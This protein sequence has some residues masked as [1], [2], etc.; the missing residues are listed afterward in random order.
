MDLVGA[1]VSH[2]HELLHLSNRYFCGFGAIGVEVLR[3]GMEHQ[4]PVAVA[5]LR[6][7]ACKVSS[8]PVDGKQRLH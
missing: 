6:F 1:K 2:L 8:D 4:V 3:G 7:D 5:L